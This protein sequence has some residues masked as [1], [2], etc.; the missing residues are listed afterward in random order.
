[1][2]LTHFSEIVNVISV[3]FQIV[4]IFLGIKYWLVDRIIPTITLFIFFTFILDIIVFGLYKFLH[5]DVNWIN[6]IYIINAVIFIPI[7]FFKSLGKNKRLRMLSLFFTF[8]VASYLSYEFF[9]QKKFYSFNSNCWLA[10]QTYVTINSFICIILLMKN[11]KFQELKTLSFLYF[12]LAFLAAYSLPTFVNLFQ[13]IFKEYSNILYTL[14]FF[15]M[16]F[17]GIIFSILITFGIL[18]FR[19]T[20]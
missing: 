2:E 20:E 13:P 7:F 10:I 5:Y 17:I 19:K 14:T 9:F 15:I 11:Y 18:E 12:N 1:M 3:F 16:N 4:P 8:C 6:N